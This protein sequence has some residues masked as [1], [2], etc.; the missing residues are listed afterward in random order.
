M[1]PPTAYDVL[2]KDSSLATVATATEGPF[3][4]GA[5]WNARSLAMTLAVGNYTLRFQNYANALGNYYALDHVSL[6]GVVS[7]RV[8]DT[9]STF[10]PLGLSFAVMTLLARK[11]RTV[12]SK[13]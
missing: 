13:G 8:P 1:A 2:V 6:D 7:S 5:A 9:G 10:G 11:W 3:L 4:G 12:R